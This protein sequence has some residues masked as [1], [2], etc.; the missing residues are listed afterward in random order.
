VKVCVEYEDGGELPLQGLIE[1][2]VARRRKAW[3][4]AHT[5]ERRFGLLLTGRERYK[6]PSATLISHLCRRF[7]TLGLLSSRWLA[8]H[9]PLCIL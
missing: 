8:L 7:S 5:G 6:I 1:E 3:S 4:A 9:L 2:F